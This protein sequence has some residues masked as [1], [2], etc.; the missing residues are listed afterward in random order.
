MVGLFVIR[1]QDLE[2]FLRGWEKKV[3]VGIDGVLFRRGRPQWGTLSQGIEKRGW[4]KSRSGVCG[5]LELE[6]GASRF[7][8]TVCA[9]CCD[10]C[11]WVR[12]SPSPHLLLTHCVHPQQS[13][14]SPT[15]DSEVQT[16]DGR[17]ANDYKLKK[18]KDILL[19]KRLG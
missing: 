12:T 17:V 16:R 6:L 7:N 14:R 8:V 2:I 18:T 9:V 15:V 3:G 5:G 10:G 13:L 4:G 19:T 11:T 1:K